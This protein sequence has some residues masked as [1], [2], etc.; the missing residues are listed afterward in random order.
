MPLKYISCNLSSPANVLFEKTLKLDTDDG[1][2]IDVNYVFAKI[3][4]PNA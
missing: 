4:L 2:V 3:L 1:N